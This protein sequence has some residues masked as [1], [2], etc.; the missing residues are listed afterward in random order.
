M[1]FITELGTAELPLQTGPA[2]SESCP[3]SQDSLSSNP[4]LSILPPAW[5]DTEITEGDIEVLLRLA[6]QKFTDR[7]L[8]ASAQE[9]AVC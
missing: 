8:Q 6:R 3:G 5:Q 9:G 2:T 7:P 4:K 1:A